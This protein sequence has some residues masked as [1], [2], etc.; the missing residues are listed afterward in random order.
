MSSVIFSI[1]LFC[2]SWV[3]GMNGGILETLPKSA[4]RG[5]G[6]LRVDSFIIVDV[7]NDLFPDAGY[8]AVELNGGLRVLFHVVLGRFRLLF[9]ELNLRGSSVDLL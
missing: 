6:F 8:L 5:G 2:P 4:E 3:R 7:S 9:W 1:W